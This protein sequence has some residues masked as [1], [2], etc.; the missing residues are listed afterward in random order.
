MMTMSCHLGIQSVVMTALYGNTLWVNKKK[1]KKKHEKSFTLGIRRINIAST[2][3]NKTK[4]K[5]FFRFEIATF[6]L[7]INHS[8]D[9]LLVVVDEND[10]YTTNA[11]N[12]QQ[13]SY[14]WLNGLFLMKLNYEWTPRA[15]YINASISFVCGAWMNITVQHCG[16]D[17]NVFLLLR[18]RHIFHRTNKTL[19]SLSFS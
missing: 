8:V 9:G 13:T 5:V 2:K 14:I 4:W 12:I 7:T 15:I 17:R 1:K 18:A 6:W 19:E 11:N 16:R 10:I 3:W